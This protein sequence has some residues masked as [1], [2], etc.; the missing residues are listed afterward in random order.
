MEGCRAGKNTNY[1]VDV[2]EASS[3]FGTESWIYMALECNLRLLLQLLTLLIG[4]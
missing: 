3:S 4:I 1:D 2:A